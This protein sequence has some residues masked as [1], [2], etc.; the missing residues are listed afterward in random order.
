M[1]RLLLK[2]KDIIGLMQNAHKIE[3]NPLFEELMTY[4][5]KIYYICLGFARNRWDAE[6][7]T[8][9]VYLKALKKITS[10]REKHMAKI[11]LLRICRNT[12]LDYTKTQRMRQLFKRKLVQPPADYQTPESQVL[13]RI[14]GSFV[15]LI[16]QW[17]LLPLL[18]PCTLREC[19]GLLQLL[20]H[21]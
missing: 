16:R 11:W 12:C 17:F 8:Q 7:L 14:L 21:D 6:E 10:L 15:E 19:D 18:A 5:Q 3:R 13:H 20:L 9:D 4:R 2:K 1:N